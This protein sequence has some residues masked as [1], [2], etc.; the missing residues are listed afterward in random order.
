MLTVDD[1][2]LFTYPVTGSA[3]ALLS[4]D[5]ATFNAFARNV[6]ND[7]ESVLR[8]YDVQDKGVLVQLSGQKTY[9]VFFFF[10]TVL[11]FSFSQK[12]T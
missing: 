6:R 7:L 11:S 2:P 8:D 3:Q 4:T 5:D 9:D 1:L 12:N 10:A